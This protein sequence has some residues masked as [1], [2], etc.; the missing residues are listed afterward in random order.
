MVKSV[1]EVH[2]KNNIKISRKELNITQ[3]EFAKRHGISRKTLSE[4][5]NGDSIPNLDL[6][7]KIATDL[8]VKVEDVFENKY[9][10]NSVEKFSKGLI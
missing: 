3:E 9:S 8:N 1:C 4:I 6:A 7:Y 2:M 10:F 5:E